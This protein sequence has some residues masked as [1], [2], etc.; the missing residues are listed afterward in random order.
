MNYPYRMTMLS[1]L[2]EAIRELERQKGELLEAIQKAGWKDDRPHRKTRETIVETGIELLSLGTQVVPATAPL[3]VNANATYQK[4]YSAARVII[5]KNQPDRLSEFDGLYSRKDSSAIKDYLGKPNIEKKQQFR[6]MDLINTQ[7]EILAAVPE[8][9]KY[10]LFDI[11]LTAYSILM[12]DELGA[13]KYLLKN[14]FL[15][16][17][18]A[19]AGV[20]LERHLKNLLRKHTPPI[21]YREKA[22]LGPLNDLCKDEIY[23]VAVWRNVQHLA[24]LRNLCDHD[25]EREPTKEEVTV[26]IDGVSAHL[27][28]HPTP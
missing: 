12:D 4:W 26:L 27:K 21:K 19:L 13:A 11:E 20:I 1:K 10:S 14:G 25:K 3:P 23:D 24:D 9:L 16:S 6:L 18:G 15:R 5:A 7:F 22:T 17:A 8:H 28:N 2:N